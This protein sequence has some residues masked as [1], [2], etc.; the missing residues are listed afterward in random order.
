MVAVEEFKK[1]E[2]EG[3]R[4]L[5]SRLLAILFYLG[6]SKITPKQLAM[7]TYLLIKVSQIENSYIIGLS[8][9]VN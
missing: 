8:A 1:D 7:V 4:I 5:D 6:Q 3:M 9:S 2:T